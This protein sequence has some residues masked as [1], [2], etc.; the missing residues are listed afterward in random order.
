MNYLVE[1]K[2]TINSGQAKI[3]N[4]NDELL[5]H[6]KELQNATTKVEELVCV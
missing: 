1:C 6:Q 5:E 4:L 2:A 3:S